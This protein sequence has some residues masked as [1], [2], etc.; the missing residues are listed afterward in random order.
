MLEGHAV[1]LNADYSPLGVVSMK[2][3][4]KLLA[5]G[6][7]E[8]VEASTRI[9]FN[10]ERTVKFVLPLVLKLIKMIRSIFKRKV[11]FNKKNVLLRDGY[12][13]AYCGKDIRGRASI[14][15]IIPKSAGGKSCFENVVACCVPCNNKKDNRLPRQAHMFPKKQAKEPT[16]MEFVTIQIRK[17]GMEDALKKLGVI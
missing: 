4:V 6:K 3:A 9:I 7:A 1:L 13:C 5:K 8:V 12:E 11:P 15:H 16:I 17:W 2:K 14:D 10:A